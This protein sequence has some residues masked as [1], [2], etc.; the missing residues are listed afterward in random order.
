M[1]TTNTIEFN[2]E[3][4]EEAKSVLLTHLSSYLGASRETLSRI[5]NA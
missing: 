2:P 4:S 5:R 3:I 1:P